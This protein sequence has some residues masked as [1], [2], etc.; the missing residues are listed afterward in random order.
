MTYSTTVDNDFEMMEPNAVCEIEDFLA[1]EEKQQITMTDEIENLVE[2]SKVKTD[3]VAAATAILTVDST[4]T[5]TAA[6]LNQIIET[7]IETERKIDEDVDNSNLFDNDGIIDPTNH[8][9]PNF[10][11]SSDSRK[12]SATC[13]QSNTD[14]HIISNAHDSINK[15]NNDLWNDLVSMFA[16]SDNI[17]S[18]IN[19]DAKSNNNAA[20]TPAV[21]KDKALNVITSTL[22]K[23]ISQSIVFINTPIQKQFEI[24]SENESTISDAGVIES[25]TDHGVGGKASKQE[26]ISSHLSRTPDKSTSNLSAKQTGLS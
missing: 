25:T 9:L 21:I 7:W 2:N 5:N 19:A 20:A 1:I 26:I 8:E 10:S 17:S 14:L 24:I 12:S 23:N 11:G 4:N 13:S 6:V 18:S 16:S 22:N 15:D 3:S